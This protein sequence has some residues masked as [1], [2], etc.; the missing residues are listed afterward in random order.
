MQ[1]VVKTLLSIALLVALVGVGFLGWQWYRKEGEKD[2]TIEEQKRIIAALEQKLDRAWAEELVADM[3]VNSL[4]KND[5]GEPQMNLTF[6]QYAPGTEKPVM[7]KDM[8]IPGEEFYVDAFVAKFERK[9]V[10][11][12][13][14]LRGK[15]LLV[16]RRVFGDRQKP[17]DGVPLYR[18]SNEVDLV[19][20]EQLQVDS[21]PSPFEK[22]LWSKFWTY[23]NDPKAAGEAGVRVAQGE[24]PHVKAVSGQVYK[25]VLRASGG[26]EITPRL[27]AAMVG[28]D[29]PAPSA[30]ASVAP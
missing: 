7:Q 23:A 20:P 1:R 5:K 24:A 19:V 4:S 15:S 12:G 17:V 29:A 18:K 27:P 21:T 26:L 30:S 2:R 16:F 10:E 9:L 6:A 28:G 13:D 22:Q 11:D 14:G 8:T 25:I 3:R